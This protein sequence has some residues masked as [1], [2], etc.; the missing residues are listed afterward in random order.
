MKPALLAFILALSALVVV[1]WVRESRLHRDLSAMD[2]RVKSSEAAQSDLQDKLNTWEA[3]INRLTEQSAATATKEKELLAEV[4]RLT[5]ELTS[6]DAELK[7]ASAA[8][9]DFTA[10][11]KARN[12]EVKKANEAI[13]KQNAALKSLVEERDAL[14]EKLNART[15]EWND[16]TEKYNKLVRS[17]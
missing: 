12:E 5:G 7:T 14:T 8:P 4:T 17:R 2:V 16:L 10:Q 11:T 13:V 3:E 6:R 15:K 1:Q 9:P